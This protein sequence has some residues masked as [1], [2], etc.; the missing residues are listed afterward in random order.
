MFTYGV[1]T[2]LH[3]KNLS[4][5]YL[6]FK[7][8]FQSKQHLF[9]YS[10]KIQF[11]HPFCTTHTFGIIVADMSQP[12]FTKFYYYYYFYFISVFILLTR[13]KVTEVL[14]CRVSNYP[15]LLL[16]MPRYGCLLSACTFDRDMKTAYQDHQAGESAIKCLFQE[17]NRIEWVWNRG[18]VDHKHGTL[19]TCPCC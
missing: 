19:T 6:F 4:C 17:H 8:K 15:D 11:S 9:D 16:K 18:H 14:I 5:F 13:R 2:N 1:L 7:L 3:P 10:F 12:T